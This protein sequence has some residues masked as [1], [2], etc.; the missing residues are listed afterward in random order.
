MCNNKYPDNAPSVYCK[1]K[2]YHPNINTI[3]GDGKICLNMLEDDCWAPSMAL[4]DVVQGIL[5]L[6]YNPN[7]GDPLC[8][9]VSHCMDEEEFAANV[10]QSLDGGLIEDYHFKRN[11]VIRGDD[12]VVVQD[13]GEAEKEAV[14]CLEEQLGRSKKEDARPTED[15]AESKVTEE[16]R[17]VGTGERGDGEG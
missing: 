2:I 11:R 8:V 14:E 4:E 9:L 1:T 3:D 13:V 12:G 16:R 15:V 17:K 6:M 5:F 10:S 7:L